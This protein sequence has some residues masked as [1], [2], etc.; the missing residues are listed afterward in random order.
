MTI[1]PEHV[2]FGGPEPLDLP[3]GFPRSGRALASLG[4]VQRAAPPHERAAEALQRATGALSTAAMARMETDMPW[5]RELS[6]EDRSWVGLIV[7][8][9][10]RGFVDWYRH[11]GD[12]PAPAAPSW[13]PRSSAPR[14]ARWPG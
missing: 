1:Q 14:P 10:I 11:A 3:G 13:P 8:A 9:G 6:A 5:F 4:V 12:E 2:P 7:Q